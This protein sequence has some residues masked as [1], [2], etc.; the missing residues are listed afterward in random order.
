MSDFEIEDD[1]TENNEDFNISDNDCDYGNNDD[2][3][4][5]DDCNIGTTNNSFEIDMDSDNIIPLNSKCKTKDKDK[6]KDNTKHKIS[7]NELLNLDESKSESKPIKKTINIKKRT[8]NTDIKALPSEPVLKLTKAESKFEI[9]EETIDYFTKYLEPLKVFIKNSPYVE[10]N[11]SNSNS[12]SNSSN[13]NK[14]TNDKLNDKSNDKS[15]DT[16]IICLLLKYQLIKDYK[17]NTPKCKVK[18]IWNDIPIQLLLNRK[19]GIHNDLSLSNLEFL[20]PNCYMTTYGLDMFKK[21]VKETVLYCTICDFPLVKFANSRKKT[22]ICLACEKKMNNLSYEKVQSSY[23]NQ[24]QEVYSDNPILSDDI[25]RPR[26][27]KDIVKYKKKIESSKNK[28]V[29]KSASNE[30][31]IQLNMTIPDISELM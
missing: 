9:N 6:T 12:N 31:I 29:N 27:Y 5:N 26:H 13:S 7:F 20:C 17:C 1:D 10:F 22:G 21:K 24:L 23:Y 25:H 8:D 16:R 2:N 28:D 14:K 19:N 18:H 11:N 3:Y 4:C 30:P 15:N